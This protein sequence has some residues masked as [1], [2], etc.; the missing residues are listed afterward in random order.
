MSTGIEQ[1]HHVKFNL[2]EEEVKSHHENLDIVKIGTNKFDINLG[3][4]KI[5]HYYKVAFSLELDDNYQKIVFLKDDSSKSVSLKELKRNANSNVTH[6]FDMTIIFFA[7]KEK[8]D[9]ETVFLRLGDNENNVTEI[10]FEATVL[11]AHQGTPLLRNGITLLPNH[12]N[13]LHSHVNEKL[14]FNIN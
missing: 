1:T 14:H 6:V 9:K 5:D 8:H 10:N 12:T 2:Q 13:H 4:L 11:G 7:S 3:Y